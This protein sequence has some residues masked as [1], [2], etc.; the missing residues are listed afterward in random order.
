MKYLTFRDDWT[1]ADKLALDFRGAFLVEHCREET[2]T[3]DGLTTEERYET[4]KTLNVGD[5]HG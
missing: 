4:L 1:L 5:T 3:D 2:P